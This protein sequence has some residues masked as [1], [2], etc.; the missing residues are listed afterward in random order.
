M[1]LVGVAKSITNYCYEK[2]YTLFNNMHILC[3]DRNPSPNRRE[4]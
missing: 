2:N 3:L 1:R 4:R